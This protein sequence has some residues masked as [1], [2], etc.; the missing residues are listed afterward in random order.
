M[1]TTAHGPDPAAGEPTTEAPRPARQ[2]RGTVSLPGRGAAAAIVDAPSLVDDLRAQ[3]MLPSTA[4]VPTPAVP[5]AAPARAA[6]PPARTPAAAPRPAAAPP[7]PPRRQ[8]PQRVQFSTKLPPALITDVK[9]F[10][11]H[12]GSEIQ[13]VVELALREYMTSRNWEPAAE[14]G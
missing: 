13:I 9:D 6:A 11:E 4:T 8:T 2:K 5:L 3:P 12:Y 10:C 7:P 14:T 1:S